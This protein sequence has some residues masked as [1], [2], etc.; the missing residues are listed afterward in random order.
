MSEKRAQH[1]YKYMSLRI[2]MLTRLHEN[3]LT[4]FTYITFRSLSGSDTYVCYSQTLNPWE[5]WQDTKLRAR[6]TELEKG[7]TISYEEV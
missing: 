1:I 2:K 5:V 6:H 4:V 3:A 7:N